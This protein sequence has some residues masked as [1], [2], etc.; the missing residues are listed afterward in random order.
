MMKIEMRAECLL[1]KKVEVKQSEYAV[2]GDVDSQGSLYEIAHAPNYTA[3]N[4]DFF[5]GDIVILK[6]GSYSNQSIDGT[7]Y[8]FAEESDIAGKVKYGK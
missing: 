1:L 4:A 2:A 7:T 5:A 6:P 3:R 8:V